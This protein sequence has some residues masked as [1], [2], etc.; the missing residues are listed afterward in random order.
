MPDHTVISDVSMTLAATLTKGLSVFLPAPPPLAKADDLLGNISMDPPTLTVFLYEIVEDPTVKNR[1]P[2]RT[3]T[4]P[5]VTLRRAPMPLILRYLI[6]PWSNDRQTDQQ[7]LGRALQTLRDGAILSG[8]ALLGGL[9]GSGEA[10]HI[11]LSPLTL[12]ERTRIWHAVHKPYRVSVSYEVRV[13]M[14]DSLSAR[15]LTPVA[16]RILDTGIPE[17]GA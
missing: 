3:E 5:T 6:T 8:P 4:P 15:A 1:P 14:L 9:A 11:T 7:M 13:V 17:G 16:D 2:I 12:E 10:L